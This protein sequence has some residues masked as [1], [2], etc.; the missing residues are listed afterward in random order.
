VG[1]GAE[2]EVITAAYGGGW[3]RGGARINYEFH[4]GIKRLAEAQ[5]ERG[6]GIGDAVLEE[7]CGNDR[8]GGEFAEGSET[9]LE[10]G[11]SALGVGGLKVE[12]ECLPKDGSG[13]VH[14]YKVQNSGNGV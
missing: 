9:V 7:R 1:V 10:I 11:G 12:V 8:V 3:G 2:E 6:G 5:G 4:V 14:E 13:N